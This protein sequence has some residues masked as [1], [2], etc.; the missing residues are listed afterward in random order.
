[1]PRLPQG[2]GG[3]LWQPC[4]VHKDF[5]KGQIFRKE[6]KADSVSRPKGRFVQAFGRAVAIQKSC[7][8]PQSPSA[9]NEIEH[10]T[11]S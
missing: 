5:A 10:C 4:A 11:K 3:A 2:P 6:P 9:H 7:P 8:A 1:M